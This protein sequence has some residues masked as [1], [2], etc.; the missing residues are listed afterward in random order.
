MMK[1]YEKMLLT[2]AFLPLGWPFVTAMRMKSLKDALPDALKDGVALQDDIRMIRLNRKY[3][4]MVSYGEQSEAF[5]LAQ[6]YIQMEK[7]PLEEQVN[8]IINAF[9]VNDAYQ[10]TD[11]DEMH[12]MLAQAIALMC[13]YDLDEQD[14][15]LAILDCAR[16]P[17][18]SN[19][20]KG[21]AKLVLS[22]IPVVDKI[23]EVAG[24]AADVEGAKAVG[25]KA[26]EYFLM[27]LLKSMDEHTDE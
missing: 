15:R 7:L 2:N 9:S 6:K 26:K 12:I 20:G 17:M 11:S 4:D 23:A 22:K 10:G 18:F 25:A 16:A 8:R 24:S 27:P 21:I 14:V 19:R 3:D 13:G 5:V 1:L